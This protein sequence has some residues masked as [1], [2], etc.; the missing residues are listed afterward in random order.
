VRHAPLTSTRS[1]EGARSRF[2]LAALLAGL[3]LAWGAPG[4]TADDDPDGPGPLP[5]RV[6][7][8]VGFTVDAAAFPDSAG[9][10]L[11]VYVR[12]PPVTLKAIERDSTGTGK[13]RLTMRLTNGFGAK[14]HEASQEFAIAPADT[15]PGFGKVVLMRFPVRPGIYR[16]R[17]KLEDLFSHRRGLGYLGRK[18]TESASVDGELTVPAAQAGRDLS[19]LEFVWPRIGGDA[20]SAFR[21]GEHAL[22]P[23]PERLYGLLASELR[24]EF[25]A[26]GLAGNQ[27]TWIWH[28]RVLDGQGQV[29]AEQESTA[30]PGPRLSAMVALDLSTAPSGAYD[31]EVKAWQEGDAGA[32]LRTARF[33]IGWRTSTWLVDPA[34]VEDI[35]H[36]LLSAEDEHRFS[37]FQPGERER[38]LEEFWRR[39]DPTPETAEN[40][41]RNAFLARVDHANQNFGGPGKGRGMFSD[42]GRVYIRYGEPGEIL[43]QVIP[44]GDETLLQAIRDIELSEDRPTG[45]VHQKGLGGDTRA[46]EVWVYEGDIGTPPD[47]DPNVSASRPRRRLVFLFVDEHGYGDY[48]LRYSTE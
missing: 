38:F 45:D 2:A 48:T 32:L 33:S 47:S 37:R 4:A 42:M 1:R 43:K 30:A 17:V 27:A 12:M 28:A 19:D 29:V 41:A 25:A 21:R 20:G 10:A 46:Y 26:R 40:E 39:R 14:S 22:L 13:L 6:S 16:L 23:N 34:D 8:R 3:L 24:A 11:E 15:I 18:V 9:H 44:A 5:W 31:L 35:V 36:F 7:G